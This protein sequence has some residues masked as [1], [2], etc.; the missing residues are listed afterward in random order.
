[1]KKYI[2]I[3]FLAIISSSCLNLRVEY[4]E[5]NY[6]RLTQFQGKFENMGLGNI[7]GTLQ[8]RNFDVSDQID[9]EHL[10]AIWSE[11]K[12]QK[13]YYH[14]WITNCADMTTD[15]IVSRYNSFRVFTGGVVQS[16]SIIVPDYIMEGQ[17]LDM[18]AYNTDDKKK[19]NYVFLSMRISLL[20]KVSLNIDKKIIL[21]KVFEVKYPRDN[22][23]VENIPVAFSRAL[24]QISDQMFLEIQEAIINDIKQNE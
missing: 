24:S 23:A 6:Y 1:M 18:I 21:N 20:K 13:Y 19:E 8:I 10:L 9:T 7:E 11:T 2:L 15:F 5:I 16:G 3:L 22:A 17:V 12:V 4:P 14:R